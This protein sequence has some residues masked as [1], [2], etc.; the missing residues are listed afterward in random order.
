MHRVLYFVRVRQTLCATGLLAVSACAPPACSES[1]ERA[2][3]QDVKLL[4]EDEG[5]LAEAARARL[6]G[7]GASAIAVLETGLYAAN[8]P[9]RLRVVRTLGEIGS[10]EARPI[11]DHLVARD[12]SPDVREAAKQAISRLR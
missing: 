1:T 11:L 7:R 6:I 2:T 9:A 5:S 10:A 12:P 4:V 8:P 3:R